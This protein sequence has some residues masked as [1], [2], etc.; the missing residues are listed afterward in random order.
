M[1]NR[2]RVEEKLYVGNVREQLQNIKKE[3]LIAAPAAYGML[4]RVECLESSVPE[5]ERQFWNEY[6]YRGEAIAEHSDGSY[7]IELDA[8]AH[9]EFETWG[10]MDKGEFVLHDEVYQRLFGERFDRENRQRL[11]RGFSLEEAIASPEWNALV[12]SPSFVIG[13][14]FDSRLLKEYARRIIFTRF[15]N[16]MGFYL[17]YV[18]IKPRLRAACVDWLEYGSR[19]VGGFHLDYDY[20]RLVGLAP[21]ALKAARLRSFE[22][23]ERLSNATYPMLKGGELNLGEVTDESLARGHVE[24]VGGA[25]GSKKVE[26]Q[27]SFEVK[28]KSG[29]QLGKEFDIVVGEAGNYVPENDVLQAI[30]ILESWGKYSPELIR[31]FRQTLERNLRK[32]DGEKDES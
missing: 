15:N 23:C 31:D 22:V 1:I 24:N 5:E 14:Y 29:L 30:N 19:L 20:G 11:N 3:G 4:R 2:F 26:T 13:N 16:A 6:F 21:E 8:F 27:K 18:P 28:S 17:S 7:K 25:A 9:P 32:G 12:R 10:K